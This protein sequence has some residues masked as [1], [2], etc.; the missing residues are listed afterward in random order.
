MI[1]K[2]LLVTLIFV[3]LGVAQETP[4]QKVL[5]RIE[6]EPVSMKFNLSIFWAIREKTEKKKGSLLLGGD[7]Q[8]RVTLGESSWISDGVVVWQYSKKNRQVVIKNFL[9]LDASMLPSSIFDRFNSRTFSKVKEVDDTYYTYRDSKDLEYKRID[10]QLTKNKQN[11]E[12]ILFVDTDDNE[13]KYIFSDIKFLK[14][15]DSSEFK[16]TA[17]D[18]VE[19]FDERN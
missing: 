3:T 4:L 1:K 15:V 13:S 9:D 7:D 2:I 12:S 8:F 19:V 18:G 5:K 14:N 6:N 10:I 17:P 16:F 11:I